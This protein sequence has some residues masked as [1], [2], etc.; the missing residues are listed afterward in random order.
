[1]TCC[2][3]GSITS[4]TARPSPDHSDLPLRVSTASLILVMSVITCAPCRAAKARGPLSAPCRLAFAAIPAYHADRLTP[5]HDRISFPLRADTGGTFPDKASSL[6]ERMQ[7][8]IP[9]SRP[10]ALSPGNEEERR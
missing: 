4:E 2:V 10:A 9:V 5:Y 6:P 7:P 8:T 3:A 1:M